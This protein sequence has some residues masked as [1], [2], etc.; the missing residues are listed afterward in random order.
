MFTDLQQPDMG[1]IMPLAPSLQQWNV[2]TN[3]GGG[4]SGAAGGPGGMARTG[5]AAE[6]SGTNLAETIAR[7]IAFSMAQ[8]A[9]SQTVD[10]QNGMA[11]QAGAAAGHERHM[12]EAVA[13]AASAAAAAAATAVI[14][15]AGEAVQAKIHEKASQGFLPFLVHPFSDMVP[16]LFNSQVGMAPQ[17]NQ[18]QFPGVFPSA[19]AELQM[20]LGI[21][22]QQQQQQD[23]ANAALMTL[24]LDDVW[25]N[26]ATNLGGVGAVTEEGQMG[27]MERDEAGP[28]WAGG[29]PSQQPRDR[30]DL[31]ARRGLGSMSLVT[32]PGLSHRAAPEPSP[33]DGAA[34]G[35]PR[36]GEQQETET[37]GTGT[38]TGTGT[39]TRGTGN[40][41][42]VE[43]AV[44]FVNPAL[45][46]CAV[47][48]KAGGGE[49]DVVGTSGKADMGGD[50]GGPRTAAAA[51][52]QAH[53]QRHHRHSS[54]KAPG[55][56]MIGASVASNRMSGRQGGGRSM[57]QQQLPEVPMMSD[58]DH[59]R[60]QDFINDGNF[61]QNRGS[62]M[63]GVTNGGAGGG[64]GRGGEREDG[65]GA[66]TGSGGDSG[67]QLPGDQQ[68]ETK[69]KE[70]G[71][72]GKPQMDQ[73]QQPMHQPMHQP[74]L[75][76]D[77]RGSGD[78]AEGDGSGNGRGAEGDGSGTG[79]GDKDC[80]SGKHMNP[81]L[82]KMRQ[83]GDGSGTGSGSLQAMPPSSG[84]EVLMISCSTAPMVL[85]KG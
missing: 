6:G 43:P 54:S 20:G 40:S 73:Q 62:S 24:C 45:R 17:Q 10:V 64:A 48:G 26:G 46:D 21:L 42:T 15:A 78:G 49:G 51:Q 25:A 68:E 59:A 74:Q 57:P 38:G 76:Q 18:Q 41:A 77:G 32:V 72:V 55:S 53:H 7:N 23:N 11:G 35:G 56:G 37:G 80:G 85:I 22:Q 2:T 8:W 33:K 5:A 9:Q 29:L 52:T 75:H 63:P 50:A 81:Q 13:A 65:C 47:V 28:S 4:V 3:S 61:M 44:H 19:S 66:R 14:A 69:I 34:S 82:A 16:P 1:L 31:V 12:V 39:R 36:G 79:S 67:D 71:A 83:Q 30:Q 70:P 27:L 60:I 58:S 84:G